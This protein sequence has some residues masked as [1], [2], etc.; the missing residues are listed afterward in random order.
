M[1]M[2]MLASIAFFIATVASAQDSPPLLSD[3]VVTALARNLSGDRALETVKE[4]SRNHRVRGSRPFRAAADMIVS[5]ARAAGLVDTKVEEFPADGKIFYGTQRSR[6]PWDADFAELWELNGSARTLV[7]SWAKQPMSLAEDSESD[8]VTA[9]LIDVG[10]GNNDKD[11]AGKNVRGKLIL[12]SSQADAAQETGVAKYGAKGIIS[13]AQNQHTAWW[14]E[15]T[16]LVRWGHLDTFSP[17]KTFAFMISPAQAKRYK[18]R[19]AR[20]ERIRMHAVVKAGQHPGSYSVATAK[21]PGTS[22]S[23]AQEEVVFSC[24]LD[25]PN[26]GANDNASGCAT[27]LEVAV[28][29]SKL[30]K[31]KVIPPPLRTIRF[32]WPPE[33]EGTMAILNSKPEWAKRIKAVVHMDMVGG[34][35]TT[36]SVFHVSSGPASLPSFVYDVGQAIGARANAQTYTYAATGES[37]YP[38][39]SQRGGKEPLLAQL[40]EFDMGSDHEIYEEAS[41]RIPAIYLHDWP[42]RYIHTTEDT[43]GRIDPTKLLRAAFIGAASGYALATITMQDTSGLRA[44]MNEGIERRRLRQAQRDYGHDRES[45]PLATVLSEYQWSE[46]V[47]S[48]RIYLQQRGPIPRVPMLLQDHGAG[49]GDSALVFSRNDSLKGPME[50]FGYNYLRDRIGAERYSKLRILNYQGLRGAGRDY[51]YEILN[52]THWSMRL[53]DLHKFVSQ[54]YGPIPMDVVL[55]YLRALE[56]AGVV[57]RIPKPLNRNTP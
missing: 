15:N 12:V 34:G 23:L 37:K 46:I 18:D 45:R 42:D 49:T 50:V 14:G 25:H 38:L 20:G 53:V 28:T 19:L 9:E 40:D 10:A 29:L 5:K 35:P 3:S 22:D 27:I 8:D 36:K 57:T 44:V 16:D 31:N 41:W 11:Y 24:H 48:L 47:K 43:P 2:R 17:A 52:M 13:Y 30:I 54:V 55:D 4:I 39:A 7:T 33:V 32:V 56:D 51:A 6:P 1:Q 26:P 21:I